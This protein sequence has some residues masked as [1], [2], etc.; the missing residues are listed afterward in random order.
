MS[1]EYLKELK[2]IKEELLNDLKEITKMKEEIEK[3]KLYLIIL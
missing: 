2:K 3:I 1:M